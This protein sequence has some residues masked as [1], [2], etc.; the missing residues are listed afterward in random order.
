M[1]ENIKKL[2]KIT[3]F[4]IFALSIVTKSRCYARQ[5]TD[6][7][8]LKAQDKILRNEYGMG[9]KIILRGVNAGGWLVQEPWMCP[10]KSSNTIQDQKT[11]ESTLVSRFGEEKAQELLNTYQ[12]NFWTESDFDNCE[13]LGMN[14]IRL[15]FWY[16]N[17]VKESGELRED[18]F[19]RIDWFV[20]QA[21]KRGI[22]VILDMH[23]APGSQNG[24]VHSG[25]ANSG[26]GLWTGAD[27][28]YN[29]NLFIKVWKLVAEHYKGNP[30]IAGYDLLNEPYSEAGK[31]TDSQVWTLYNSTYDA[32]RSIDKDHLIIMEATWEPYNLPNPSLYGWENVMYEYHSYNYDNTTDSD[33]QLESINKKI[34]LINAMAYNVPSYIGETS[35]FANMDSWTKCLTALN[36]TDI[37]WTLWNYKV[38]GDGTNSW[39]LYNINIDSANLK[40]DSFESIKNKWSA[41]VTNESY[42]N[43]E[44]VQIIDKFISY[45]FLQIK[46][47]DAAISSVSNQ[48]Y[49]GKSITPSVLVKY[50]DR[51]L[52]ENTDYTLKYS[53]NIECG[54]A[55]IIVTG[56]GNYDGVKKIT[57]KILPESVKNFTALTQTVSSISLKWTKSDGIEGYCIYQYKNGKFV[58]IVSLK[59]YHTS[60][61]V[62]KLKSGSTYKFKICSYTTIDGKMHTGKESLLTTATKVAKTKIKA[63]VKRKKIKL[64]WKKVNG[65]RGYQIYLASGKK[66]KYKK[67]KSISSGTKR[68]CTY[69]IK[70]RGTYFAKI[71]A[72]SVIDNKKILGGYSKKIKIKVK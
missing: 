3:I 70:K 21:G 54:T 42:I 27:V 14:V 5:I 29:Q 8:F 30:I 47:G 34:D 50:G 60:Y 69:K 66:G 72:Y 53:D 62:S 40:R 23:G 26:L 32:I 56:K 43:K 67:I 6:S 2:I 63:K 49:T 64:S 25:D 24:E 33:A 13:N 11:I 41:S 57:F 10:T 45:S 39:G 46:I 1:K 48:I 36:N 61:K 4:F 58:Q 44:L 15:P 38:T 59:S 22:Y 31:Y 20:E 12:D 37:S 16:L 7:D 68:K 51:T 17:I 28:I 55:T 35:F 65:A 52:V 71:R 18:A 19:T 9:S